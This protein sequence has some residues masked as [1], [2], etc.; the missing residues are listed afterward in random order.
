ME[1]ITGSDALTRFLDDET[2]LDDLS[3]NLRVRREDLTEAVERMSRELKDSSKQIEKLQ[4]KLARKDSGE[5]LDNVQQVD[6]VKVLTQEV[7]G[8]D[9]GS[10]RQLAD[11]MKN[12]IES[13]VVVLGTT[14][15]GKVSLIVMVTDDLTD[16]ISAHEL[17]R[18]IAP[19]IGGGGGG[20]PDMA[21]AGGKRVDALASALTRASER[22]AELVKA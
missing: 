22:V 8:L 7:S 15:D 17:I 2:I 16:R 5:A 21:E 3:H 18:E 1:A 20:K 11:Q 13:G 9:R 10:L 19:I 12:Q 6:G 14:V 4:L